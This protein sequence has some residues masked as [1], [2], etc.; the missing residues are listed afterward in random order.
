MFTKEDIVVVR[1]RVECGEIIEEIPHIQ[2]IRLDKLCEV[3]EEIKDE[4]WTSLSYWGEDLFDEK[5]T[6]TQI[7]EKFGEVLEGEVKK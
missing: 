5:Y 7:D 3:V 2:A 1:E 4:L 6:I